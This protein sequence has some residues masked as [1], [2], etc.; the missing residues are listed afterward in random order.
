MPNNKYIRSSKRER[1]LVNRYREKGW[2]AA[3]TAGSHSPIDVFAWNPKLG[4]IHFI[5][6]KTHKSAR[7]MVEKGKVKFNDVS[8]WSWTASWQ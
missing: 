5:Q 2:I 3:R 7:N 1:E 6:V 4:Q 8:V